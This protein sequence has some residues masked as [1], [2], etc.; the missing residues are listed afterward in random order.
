VKSW[1]E[2]EEAKFEKTHQIVTSLQDSLHALYFRTKDQFQLLGD[3]IRNFLQVIFFEGLVDG[4]PE[5]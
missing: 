5:I 2:K 4:F 3:F 1:E